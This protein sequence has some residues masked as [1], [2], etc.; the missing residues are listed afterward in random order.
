MND[1]TEVLDEEFD[2]YPSLSGPLMKAALDDV[3]KERAKQDGELGFF[4]DYADGTCGRALYGPTISREQEG[5]R[6]A[7]RKL[8]DASRA[9]KLTWRHLLEADL[10]E[11][12]TE[13][14]PEKLRAALVVLSSRAVSWI[15]AIDRRKD[16]KRIEKKM[17]RQLPLFP[18]IA[19]WFKR[20]FRRPF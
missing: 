4:R 19:Q 5:V 17:L 12:F 7:R 20:L 15:E 14:D 13:S 2:A 1:A 3:A 10:L 16:E 18:R 6:E 9:G 11:T 8:F